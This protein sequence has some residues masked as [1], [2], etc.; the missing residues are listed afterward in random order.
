MSTEF[1]K[2]PSLTVYEILH[3]K[4]LWLMSV[5]VH[6]VLNYN[7]E[8]FQP[9]QHSPSCSDLL[10]GILSVMLLCSHA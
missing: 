4:L 7:L 5:V 3:A 6:I 1:Y 2:Q 8:T 10:L 9:P